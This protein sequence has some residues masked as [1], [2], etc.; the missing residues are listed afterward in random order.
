M[1]G[2]ETSPAKVVLLA[3]QL[4]RK[5][6]IPTLKTLIAQHPK[7]LHRELVLRILLSHLPETTESSKYVPL[8]EDLV[9]GE[10]SEESDHPVDK[11]ALDDLSEVEAQKKVR[12]LHL[13]HLKW[14][15][16]PEDDPADPF[17]CFL[18]LR[19][20]Q[21]DD[22]TGLINQL[23]GLLGPFL[24]LSTYLRTWTISSV[25][26]LVRLNYDYRPG[27]I[28][29]ITI[30][31]F[32]LLDDKAGVELLLSRTGKDEARDNVP[33][34]GRD[35][36]GLIGPWMYGDTRWKRR[37]LRENSSIQ[38]QMLTPLDGIPVANERCIAWEEVFQW[39]TE[40]AINSWKVAVG[41]VEQWD[42]P[43][44]S[45]F[46][47]YGDGVTWLDE[48]D[49]QHLERRYARAAIASAYLISEESMEAL[50]GINRILSRIITLM[51]QDR[52]PTLQAAGALLSPVSGL[53]NILL[54]RNAVHLRN[55]L[56]SDQNT[57]TSP[58]GASIRHNFTLRRAGELVLL[59]HEW[60]QEQE[61]SRIMMCVD[62]GPKEDDKFW[63]RLRNEILWLR[64]WGAEELSEGADVNATSGRGIFGK[65]SKDFVEAEILQKLLKNDRFALAKSIY[66]TSPDRPLSKEALV[67]A[68]ISA[69]MNA[70]DNATNANKT[71][72]GVKRS[73][74]ILNAFPDSL[75]GSLD[76]VQLSQLL[77][78]THNIGQ[79]RLVFKQGE[80]F[81]PVTLR[82]HGDP[83]SIIGKLLDQNPRS[84]TKINDFIDM[85]RT[86]VKAGLTVRDVTGRARP[87]D[88]E[89]I[90]EQQSIAEKRVVS[91]CVDA[92]LAEDDFETG[93][94]YVVT[95]LKRIAGPA[96]SRTPEAAS[97]QSGLLAEVAPKT[98]D[99]WSWRAALQA[100]KYRRT[101]FTT[102]PTHLGNASGNPEIRHLEQRMECLAQALRLAP[103]ATLQE[104]I[105][106]FRR[107]EE[108]LETQTKR[109]A[110]QEA[111]W[112]AQG[113]D[114]AM[115]GGYADTP[116]RRNQTT[117][118]SS[119]AAEEAPMSLFDLSKASI[120]RAQ[121]GLA[122]L[123]AARSTG[124]Y[125]NPSAATRTSDDGSRVGTPDSAAIKNTTRKRDQLKNAAV[126]GLA[127][128]IGWLV[129]AKPIQDEEH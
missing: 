12:K 71:R 35:L 20:L 97:Q 106:V 14:P 51:D 39:I 112:D 48:E 43:G 69:A 64:S 11:Q 121:S 89:Q 6:D 83:I 80:P 98:M 36:Q 28:T 9:T 120:S 118:G 128:G 46:G 93:Y 41:A 129:G 87:L 78:L 15:Y 23:P 100:G 54:G 82:V 73:F 22:S 63:V 16:A 105:N 61:L 84:Y 77:E 47:S 57:L 1:A 107:C 103:K 96:Q 117:S 2:S 108:E 13:L 86:M 3:V 24:H 101:E 5:A 124:G 110:E 59:Q 88:A 116:V 99:D 4:A 122:A 65:L 66:E 27:I 74:D 114:Q 127:T 70:Y 33:N 68:V 34:V 17:V 25:L 58:K 126:G 115:P 67:Q 60:E 62:N 29:L 125:R 30:P 10:I 8:L 113:D 123:S 85:G 119:R 31:E 95:R 53:E 81:K 21:I 109:E 75:Q 38:M 49:Q 111:A 104:I 94:S 26:P 50:N 52:I 44:D 19:A 90:A 42:G 92:A 102:K 76:Q 32:E 37:K 91:M 55:D 72:G 18:V 45:D 40:K 7:P 79:Y 56:L